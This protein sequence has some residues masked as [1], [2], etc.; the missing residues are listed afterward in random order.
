MA[1]TDEKCRS[2][3]YIHLCYHFIQ[4]KSGFPGIHLWRDD[5][6]CCSCYSNFYMIM[7]GFLCLCSFLYSCQRDKS[8]HFHKY[9]MYFIRSHSHYCKLTFQLPPWF[10]FYFPKEL[11]NI[12][13][14]Q[15]LAVSIYRELSNILLADQFELL[16]QCCSAVFAILRFICHRV[17]KIQK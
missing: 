15:Q 16:Q 12:L 9:S 5:G 8:V 4:S 13:L 14:L 11:R 7:Y 6:L 10:S 3:R 2:W 17:N 1:V